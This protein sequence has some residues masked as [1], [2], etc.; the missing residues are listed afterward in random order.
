MARTPVVK[1]GGRKQYPWLQLLELER[2]RFGAEP[3]DVLKVKRTRGRPANPIPRSK[4]H[5]SLTEDEQKNLDRVVDGLP[6]FRNVSRGQ[7]IGLLIMYLNEKL[8]GIDLSK[9]NS[10]TQIVDILEGNISEEL[11]AKEEPKS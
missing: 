4:V 5:I 10:F 9:I 1:K 7:V 11:T 6:A 2:Q 8:V 3:E